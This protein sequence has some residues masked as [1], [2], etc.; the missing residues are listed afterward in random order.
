MAKVMWAS[1]G[2]E[3]AGE[4]A[5]FYFCRW[6]I[7]A[8]LHLPT[9]LI[10]Y[11]QDNE[12]ITETKRKHKKETSALSKKRRILGETRKHDLFK[13]WKSRLRDHF[14]YINNLSQWKNVWLLTA[15]QY[16]RATMCELQL[17]EFT[18]EI[19]VLMQRLL[20]TVINQWHKWYIFHLL[21]SSH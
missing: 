6:K 11:E 12:K 14:D 9:V 7:L 4:K 16:N 20:T 1:Q 3:Q 8:W 13:L 18:R 10:Q 5:D 15:L 21:M 19:T 2:G 17:H